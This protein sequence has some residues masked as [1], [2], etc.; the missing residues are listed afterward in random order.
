MSEQEKFLARWS[1]RKRESE[2]SAPP[3]KAGVAEDAKLSPEAPA[4]AAANKSDAEAPHE[5]FDVSQL[6]SLDSITADTDIRNFLKPGVPADLSRAALRRAWAADPVIRDFIG[7]SENSWDFNSDEMQGFGPLDPGD[8]QKLLAQ[9]TG[10]PESVEQTPDA[11]VSAPGVQ[12]DASDTASNA[13]DEVPQ[14]QQ[15]PETG[16]PATAEADTHAPPETDMLQSHNSYV[17]SQQDD[18]DRPLPRRRKSGGAL[19]T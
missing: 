15:Q 6:P 2:E 16:P 9:A 19:P 10:I 17:A 11:T 3:A 8:L 7:L 1:R 5:A 14:A 4:N 18:S 12:E 13:R